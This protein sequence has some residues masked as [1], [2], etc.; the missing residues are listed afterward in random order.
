MPR[1]DPEAAKR[2]LDD[3]RAVMIDIREPAEFAREHVAGARS[4]PLSGLATRDLAIEADKAAIFTCRS[5]ART[6]TNA[7]MLAAKWPEQAYLLEGGN[8]AW[9][10]AGLPILL[11]RRMPIDLMRQVQIGAGSL[12]LLGTL[13]AALVSPWFL[14][15][16]GVVGAGLMVAGV[17][18]FCGMARLLRLA[19]WNRALRA[20]R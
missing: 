10:R 9:K 4:A 7:G 17:T 12:A 19:P 6:A 5:G 8:E 1:I 20:A 16:P 3:G 11:D 14:V 13:L 18:G 15:V 2:M